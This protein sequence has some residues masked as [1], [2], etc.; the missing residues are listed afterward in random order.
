VIST[1]RGTVQHAGP[2]DLVVEVGGVGFALAVPAEVAGQ[3]APGD[4]IFLFTRM[5]VREDSLSLYG[6]SSLEQRG[7]FDLLLQVNGVG[8]KLALAVLSHLAADVLRSA[9]VG[10]QVDVLTR[11]PGVGRK[12]AE[13]IAFHL[14]D[15][16]E[17]PGLGRLM[18][19]SR[20]D[21]DILQAL[22]GLGYT[23]VEAQAALQSIPADAPEDPE[24]RVRLALQYF[25]RP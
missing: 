25:A 14:K 19:P 8:P 1:I 15:K 11:V 17:A 6:F 24:E 2:G 13:K 21:T 9:V 7:L 22:T 18:P 23:L 12:T 4:P 5:V 16:L 10:A 3:A 20:A